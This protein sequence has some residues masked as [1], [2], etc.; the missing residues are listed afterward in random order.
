LSGHYKSQ[1][2]LLQGTLDLLILQTLM[3][4][5]SH[6]YGIAQAIRANSG[7]LLRVDAGSLYP[8][9]Q[10]LQKQKWLS[11]EWKVSENKQ[12]VKVYTLTAAGKRQLTQERSRWEQI[13]GAVAG[14]LNPASKKVS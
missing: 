10:R 14:V 13:T 3:W 11:A 9:L 5:P 1:M 12:D 2:E 4:G 6:G 8:A 7:E